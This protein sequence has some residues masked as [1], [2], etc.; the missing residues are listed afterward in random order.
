MNT[1]TTAAGVVYLQSQPVSIFFPSSFTA[2]V[3]PFVV[4]ENWV[5]WKEISPKRTQTIKEAGSAEIERVGKIYMALADED[6]ALAETGL[7]EYG[8]LLDNDLRDVA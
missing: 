7:D 6:A 4:V 1:F 2:A 5:L 8:H 3:S